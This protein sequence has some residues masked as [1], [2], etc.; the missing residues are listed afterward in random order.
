MAAGDVVATV[1]L[2]VVAGAGRVVA[3]PPLP[4]T[5][6]EI[7]TPTRRPAVGSCCMPPRY[8]RYRGIW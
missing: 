3:W 6:I 7:T 5:A 4:L 2:V 1:R 8:D